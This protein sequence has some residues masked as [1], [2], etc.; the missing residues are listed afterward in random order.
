MSKRRTP[1]RRHASRTV[2]LAA[3]TRGV[4]LRGESVQIRLAVED[5]KSSVAPHLL[6][7]R[8]QRVGAHARVDSQLRDETLNED[9]HSRGGQERMKPENEPEI[10]RRF[11]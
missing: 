11:E 6:Q 8:D 9:V 7:L 2:N 3:L 10:E 4:E 5:D 1:K